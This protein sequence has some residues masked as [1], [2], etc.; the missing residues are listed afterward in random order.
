[1]KTLLLTILIGTISTSIACA[2]RTTE[3]LVAGIP[4]G[5]YWISSL[6]LNDVDGDTL[7]HKYYQVIVV[8][9]EPDP[10][11]ATAELIDDCLDSLSVASYNSP[12]IQYNY[13]TYS[14]GMIDVLFTVWHH[15]IDPTD[16]SVQYGEK[17]M[18]RIFNGDIPEQATHYLESE[19]WECTPGLHK[20]YYEEGFFGDWIPIEK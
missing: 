2:E 5:Y 16:T 6:W 13:N 9:G 8:N 15:E 4:D 14:P 7:R 18:V 10:V 19:I 1:M 11:T 17:V 20:W 12:E 3:P